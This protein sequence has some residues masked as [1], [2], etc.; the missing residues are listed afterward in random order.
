MGLFGP[1]TWS[2]QARANDRDRRSDER[3]HRRRQRDRKARRRQEWTKHPIR[4][5]WRSR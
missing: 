4:T 2:E 1:K 5:A 3:D